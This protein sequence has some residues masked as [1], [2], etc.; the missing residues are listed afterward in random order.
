MI[1]VSIKTDG[2]KRA[3]RKI[4][5]DRSDDDKEFGVAWRT[6]SQGRLKM[7]KKR[8]GKTVTIVRIP[9]YFLCFKDV[10][11]EVNYLHEVC[12]SKN[13]GFGLSSLGMLGGREVKTS[14]LVSR[15]LW[16]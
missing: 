9:V 13:N 11:P 6:D 7:F 8:K 5:A 10:L 2:I 15:R 3:C 14:A 4:W 16:V 12:H 1:S